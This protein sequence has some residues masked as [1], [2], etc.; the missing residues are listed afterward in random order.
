M[1]GF[2][3]H[4]DATNIPPEQMV[5]TLAPGKFRAQVLNTLIK[6]TKDEDGGMFVVTFTSEGG[7]IDMRYNL[8][9][10]SAKAVEIAHKQLSALCHA[11]GVFKL[12]MNN[13][14]AAIRGAWC[15]IEVAKQANTEY[16]EV[17]KV[18]DV[19]GN[20]PG[21]PPTQA[22]TSQSNAFGAQPS[23]PANN[24]PGQFGAGAG[25]ASP[26][27]ANAW[28]ANSSAAPAPQT[29]FSQQPQ[30]SWQ[31]GGTPAG[32]TDKPPWQK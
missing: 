20:E 27:P 4:F 6:P 7:Q 23:P 17:K 12:D 29:G 10:N 25:P 31:Q 24:A 15:V 9:N 14:G 26:A 32:A 28:G 22:P 3:Y 19:N 1:T 16:M 30:Q 18:F 5:A 11:T 13:E 21:K 2:N 8:W